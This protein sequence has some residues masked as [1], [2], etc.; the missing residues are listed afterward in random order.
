[1]LLAQSAV[2]WSTSL[3]PAHRVGESLPGQPAGQGGGIPLSRAEHVLDVPNG[4][5]VDLDLDVVPRG[6]GRVSAGE[7]LG[8]RI[9]AMVGV[10]SS[11]VREVDAAEK[12]DVVLGSLRMAADDEFLAVAAE[13][14]HALVKHHFA[15]DVVDVLRQVAVLLAQE[16][17]PVQVRA[18]QQNPDQGAAAG[19]R[20]HHLSD[21]QAVVGQPFV[22]V[23]APV[24][25]E[26][27]GARVRLRGSCGLVRPCARGSTALPS[28]QGRIRLALLPRCDAVRNQSCAESRAAAAVVRA[29]NGVARP[30][31]PRRRRSA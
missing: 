31:P 26:H 3:G 12:G 5:A 6:T 17:Q 1:M 20:R 16:S 9:A 27:Q 25:E 28:V 2:G 24:G 23:T 19:G 4:W 10:V 7:R 29:V 14:P 13:R 8:L 11:A 22:R 18:L 21:G 30:A 15:A